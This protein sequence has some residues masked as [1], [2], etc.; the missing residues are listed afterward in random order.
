M[1][2]FGISEIYQLFGSTIIIVLGTLPFAVGNP[3]TKFFTCSL[4]LWVLTTHGRPY[5]RLRILKTIKQA[6]QSPTIVSSK[7]GYFH[8]KYVMGR[9]SILSLF[10]IQ[11][12]SKI[13]SRISAILL[14]TISLTSVIISGV[15]LFVKA[16]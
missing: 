1:L 14:N 5:H 16:R 15:S 2:N 3:F 10:F 7:Y 9:T 8:V 12:V 13:L 6:C 4:W 11:P